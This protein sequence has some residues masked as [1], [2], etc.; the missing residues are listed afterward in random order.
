MIGIIILVVLFITVLFVSEYFFEKTNYYKKNY[1]ETNKLKGND[2]VDYVNTG[3]TFAFYGIDYESAGVKGLNLAL[4]PQSLEADF[5][6]LKHFENR[7][8]NGATV[9]LVISDLA[10]AKRE[11]S[12]ASINEKYYKVLNSNEINKYNVLKSIRARFFPV[13]YSWKNFLRFHRDIK[14]DN[15]YGLKVNENDREAVEADAFI[16]C[17]SWMK[18]FT[19]DNLCDAHQRERF[20]E[21]FN[22]TIKIVKSMISWCEVRGYKPI[23]VNLP[24]SDEMKKCFS[25]EFLDA[26]YY[27]NVKKLD[28]VLFIDF[29]SDSR[30]SDY[31]LYLDSCRLNQAGR[32]IISRILLREAGNSFSGVRK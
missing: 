7:Y 5:R 19:L 30:L 20:N 18:E 11:Y 15:E 22:Y 17:K 13:L 12:E 9:F 23:V 32:T 10:F 3:S 16:R 1:S 24:V 21:T 25:S 14:P 29:Q 26:F 2:K 6:M 4:C 31:L 8:N 28:S 27:D